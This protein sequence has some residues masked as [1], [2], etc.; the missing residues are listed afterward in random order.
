MSR[1]AQSRGSADVLQHGRVLTDAQAWRACALLIVGLVLAANAWHLSRQA[2][3][4]AWDDAWYL[5]NSFRFFHALRDGLPAFLKEYASS[6]KIKAPLI[7]LLPLPLYALFGV[8]E[9]VALWANQLFFALTLFF[10]HRIAREL[11][12]ERAAWAAVIAAA[13]TPLLYG[14]S[15]VFLVECLLTAL[16]AWAQWLILRARPGRRAA[17]QLGAAAGLGLLAKVMFP[18]YA[19]GAVWLKRRELRDGARITL[20]VAAALAASWYAFNAV[21]V[22]GFAFSAGFGSVVLDSGSA[23]GISGLSSYLRDVAINGLSWPGVACALVVLALAGPA[24]WRVE[25]ARSFLL[26]WLAVPF[27]AFAFGMNKDIR[28]LAPALP[29]LAVF[30]GA[31]A[32][33]LAEKGRGW[34]VG[35]CAVPMLAVLAAQT[36]GGAAAMSYNGAPIRAERWDRAALIAAAAKAAPR[37]TFAVALEH[38]ELNANNLSSLSAA[39]GSGP[40][41]VSL[42]YA[43]RSAEGALIRLKDKGADHLIVFDG[44]PDAELPAFLNRANDGLRALLGTRSLPAERLSTVSLAAGV[45]ATVYRLKP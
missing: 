39:A 43:Q 31:A 9:K 1:I 41:F 36:F 30:L 10:V 11:H 21:Y 28:Y 42:G 15:R 45:K 40:R 26:V 32:A 8:G 6:F 17:A 44:V 3:A 37:G 27:A 18:L 34:V 33:T 4:P 38:A 16:V 35:A 22:L 25:S 24:R 19:A 13:L 29:A 5:E 20:C 2:G 12:G 7:S 23:A 14:L